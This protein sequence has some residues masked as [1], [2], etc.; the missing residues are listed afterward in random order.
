MCIVPDTLKT[1]LFFTFLLWWVLERLLATFLDLFL[2]SLF[3]YSTH[4]MQLQYDES[5]NVVPCD[6]S[7]KLLL[8]SDPSSL[9][10]HAFSLHLPLVS[11]LSIFPPSFSHLF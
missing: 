9:S 11:F 5:K 1:Y 7:M 8:A 10:C 6:A 2:A 3:F 4:G